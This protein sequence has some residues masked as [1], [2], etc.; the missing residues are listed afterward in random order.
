MNKRFTLIE[1][2]VVVSIIGIL[3]SILMP[4]IRK[5]REKAMIALC[6]SNLGQI[7]KSC[8]IY[9][10]DNNSY[11]PKPGG[12]VSWVYSIDSTIAQYFDMFN[13]DGIEGNGENTIYKCP[14]N[15]RPPRGRKYIGSHDIWLMDHYS[16]AT[17][18]GSTGASFKGESSP[19]RAES[20]VGVLATET[21]IW[22]YGDVSWTSN[23]GNGGK[24]NKY[25]QMK[26]DP[27]GYSQC[28][29]DGS[30]KWVSIKTINI[31]EPKFWRSGGYRYYYHDD[32]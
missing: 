23:H 31:S 16:L 13:K 10:D 27:V 17:H 20:E 9:V 32:N 12:N 3:A 19:T 28:K 6:Q 15:N 25:I 7:G 30:V 5:A 11:F 14:S 8:F 18:L 21:L 29:T 22:E 2:L 24:G 26:Y 1:L 4:S